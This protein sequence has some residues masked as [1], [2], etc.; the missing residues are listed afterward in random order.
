MPARCFTR[1]ELIDAPAGPHVY[2]MGVRFQDVDAA[3]VIFFARAFEYWSDALFAGLERFGYPPRRLF[4]E[5]RVI[6]PVKHAEAHYVSPLRF[7]DRFAVTVVKA[8]IEETAFT[9]GYRIE[10]LP[11]REPAVVGEVHQ[12]CVDAQTFRRTPLPEDLRRAI[13]RMAGLASGG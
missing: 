11:H 5:K 12:V 8:A 3:G 6:T 2:E 13:E 10:R 4:E 7:S 1:E 9:L